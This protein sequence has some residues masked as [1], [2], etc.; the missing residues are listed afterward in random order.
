MLGP[1]KVL[2][3][4]LARTC[5]AVVHTLEVDRFQRVA[6]GHNMGDCIGKATV[7]V[8]PLESDADH[9]QPLSDGIVADQTCSHASSSSS[10]KIDSKARRSNLYL[11]NETELGAGDPDDE[12]LL[13]ESRDAS[14]VG[15]ETR[16]RRRSHSFSESLS[17][18]SICNG[19]TETKFGSP[20][21][22]TG[23]TGIR[24]RGRSLSCDETLSCDDE[25]TELLGRIAKSFPEKK[26][27][28]RIFSPNNPNLVV[29]SQ[30]LA[31]F[32]MD[33]VRHH[34]LNADSPTVLY[35]D[36]FV[37]SLFKVLQIE[38]SCCVI[39][40][41]YIKRLLEKGKG[42]LKITSD[43][44]RSIVVGSCLLAS[45]FMDD[46][47]TINIDFARALQAYSLADINQLEMTFVLWL[48]WELRVSRT[49]Y[50]EVYWSL[51]VPTNPGLFSGKKI[52]TEAIEAAEFN[53][54]KTMERTRS[55]A[56][57][58]KKRADSMR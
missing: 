47:S 48:G 39:A 46:L 2:S 43:N 20:V 51:S 49:N 40:Y 6:G 4:C 11:V 5:V 26:T 7:L 1:L 18:T 25:E 54:G 37:R 29:C 3:R 24:S 10:N 16:S 8:A 36:E 14:M 27:K 57:P 34:G 41:I 44:W 28:T 50:A 55:K 31:I 58:K 30:N 21:D 22:A 38:S 13:I 15:N 45:K 56:V 9:V 53:A 19:L 42:R 17:F 35:I 52:S 33:S 23:T 32:V 12:V